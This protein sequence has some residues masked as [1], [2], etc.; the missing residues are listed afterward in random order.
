MS[1]P[2]I[3][4]LPRNVIH[5]STTAPGV[6][7]SRAA[8]KSPPDLP[9]RQPPSLSAAPNHRRSACHLIPLSCGFSMEL[10]TGDETK[11]APPPQEKNRASLNEPKK[12]IYQP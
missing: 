12:S 10:L 5:E 6:R 8:R 9:Q 2:P 3:E 7:P 11:S 1:K 4:A